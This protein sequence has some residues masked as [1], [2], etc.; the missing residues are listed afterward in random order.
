MSAVSNP[1]NDLL[2]R[3]AQSLR[4]EWLDLV[5]VATRLS[6]D[7][8]DVRQV[9]AKL[10]AVANSS[11]DSITRK[12]FA[13]HY[14]QGVGYSEEEIG[15]FGQTQVLSQFQQSKKV[16]KYEKLT[17]LS[18]KIPGS[19]KEIVQQE[20]ARVMRVLNMQTSESLWDFIVSALQSCSDEE[21][22]HSAGEKK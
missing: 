22:L 14:M 3:S 16:E 5:A 17:H 4:A 1:L 19:Q 8:E 18:F 12:I 15:N 20:L 13:I 7:K 6:K 21:L 11:E 2:A 10:A 9:A